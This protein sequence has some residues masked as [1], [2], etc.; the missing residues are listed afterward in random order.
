M[1]LLRSA[2]TR[3]SEFVRIAREKMGRAIGEAGG[4]E[5]FFAG[6]LD[7]DG[8]ICDVRVCA[9]GNAEAV[10]AFCESLK[11]REVVLHNHPSGDLNPSDADL[12]LS[13]LFG[14]EGHGVY[15]VDNGLSRVYVIVE[16]FLPEEIHRLSPNELERAFRPNG[17]LARVLPGFE[18]RPQ[19]TEMMDAVARAFNGDGIAVVEA[20]TG[21]G[22][23]LAYLLPAV[24]WA[25]R[26]RERVVVSTKTINLQEQIIHKDIPALTK[27]LDESFNAVL[28][29]GR[30]NYL[31]RRRLARALSEATLFEDEETAET[32]TA[33]EEWSRKT[34]DGS[35]SDLP[36]VPARGVWSE[37]CSEAD[38]CTGTQCPSA[39]A[40]FVMKA[41]RDIAKADLI[42]ANHHMLFS[43]LAIK[44]E[45]GSFSA[46][47]VLPAYRR[48]IFDEAHNIED[49]ATQYFGASITR[50]GSLALFGRFVRTERGR[51]RGLI[52]YI[53]RKLVLAAGGVAMVTIDRIQNL[54]DNE[55]LPS[56]AVARE[57]VVAAFDALRG[58]ASEK[59]G[60][61]GRD[62]KWRLTE[63]ALRD[64][65]LREVHAGC[66][67][68]AVEE[69]LRCARHCTE[70][71]RSLKDITAASAAD[72]P[73]FLLEVS[74]LRGYA[75]R[76]CRVAN[77]LGE[78]T[79]ETL[80]PNTVRWIE[81]DA[82]RA[83]FVRL[84]SCPLEVGRPL[85][86][87]VYAN[88]RTV[89]MTSATL[90]VQRSFGYLFSRIGLDYVEDRE[91]ETAVLDSPFDFTRQA[92]LCI[93]RDLQ[94]PDSADFLEQTVDCIRDA[95][96]ITKGHAFVL[97]TSFY[98]LDYT[99][100]RLESEL[101]HAGIL[102]LKQGSAARSRM[103]DEFRAAPS[104]VLF[105][106]D[107]FWEGV[108]VVGE[109]LQCV[110]LPKLPFRVPTEPTVQAR[111]EAIDEAGGNSF[112]S[113]TV[114]Q[115]IIKFRQ[116]FGRLIRHRS[117][118]GAILV[119][120]SRVVKRHYG[121]L[122]LDSLPGLRIVNGPRKGVYQALAEF[123]ERREGK[124][125]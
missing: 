72:E 40:C 7:G 61:L 117:D 35:V 122:F 50:I 15:I 98:A 55:L 70:L 85:A 101:R 2:K 105:A 54:I 79:S 8:L 93:P 57:T 42:I 52:P 30:G 115:A 41:R 112:L 36:F 38:T 114:P 102:P 49:A 19:Q 62:I 125:P 89:I 16:P 32:L 119:L 18:V 96:R 27:C 53:K 64:E 73:P 43:D 65:A 100:T 14:H 91:P 68:P 22:K 104:G 94:P 34:S 83:K 60:Q 45:V 46:L 97:F 11:P 82:Y 17:R 3:P 80:Q 58:V 48:V 28:V 12:D 21:V 44:K 63:E 95:L 123:F 6:A 51:E 4:N 76:L 120:D 69:L 25:V 116:G 71:W 78:T 47:A 107:S 121:R 111:A 10:P 124:G 87:W 113:Y 75:E 23:T 39:K 77:V 118:R 26:N 67:A 20:P 66:V 90:A 74:Q 92:V 24:L 33:L 56:L 1:R 59:C 31:C 86:E 110:I 13:A 108:D 9:R 103:L 99:Y 88:L 109:S 29:K 84:A 106:T 81:I 5:V 37:V